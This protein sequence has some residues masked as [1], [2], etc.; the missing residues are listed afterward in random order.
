M[1]SSVIGA[2]RVML[3]M[4]SA[5]FEAGAT[6]AIRHAERLERRIGQMGDRLTGIGQALTIGLTAP[7]TAFGVSA[8]D[9]ASDA[10]ELESAFTQTF[11][12]LSGEMSRWAEETGDAMGR[13]TQSMQ[14]M[15]NTFGIF[16]NQAAP[17]REAAA[18]MSRTFSVLAQDLSSFYNVAESDA[19]A[20]LRSGLAGEAEPLRDFGVFLT[21]ASVKA[22]ALEMGLA[23]ASGEISEQA[24]IMARYQLIMEGTTNAQGDVARTSD[25]TANRIRAARAAF[26]ELQVTVG[27]K[28][29]PVITP[30]VEKLADVLNAFSRLPPGVQT[31]AVGVG[32][33]AAALGPLLMGIGGIMSS[34]APLIAKLGML[35]GSGGV[36]AGVGTGFTGLLATL[37]PI[38]VP[39]AAVAAAGALIYA[40]W[41]KIAPV[42]EQLW[43]T[44]QETLGPP[45]EQLV[46]TITATF[47]QF[48]EGPL[49]EGVR[50]AAGKL[51]EFYTA[52]NRV[53]GSVLI[54]IL[55]TVVE[56]V[57]WAFDLV[58]R[59]IRLVNQLLT[60]DW[61]AAWNSVKG[62]VDAVAPG[63]TGLVGRMVDGVISAFNRL[64]APF[65]WVVEQAQRVERAFFDMADK[66]TFRSWVPDM[67]DLIG[68]NFARLQGNMVDPALDATAT[69]ENAFATMA[70][71]VLGELQ[72]MANAIK[73][74]GFF[75]ILN[76]GIGLATKYLPGLLGGGGTFTGG[77]AAWARASAIPGFAS[78]GAMRLGGMAGIDRN[79]L[80][81]NGSPLA[82]VSAGEVLNVSPANANGGGAMHVTVTMDP[83]TG[84]LGAFVAD[85]AGRVLARATPSLVQAGAD[86]GVAKM[87][88]LRDRA[89][90]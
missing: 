1:A 59:S 30:L 65:D 9:A 6:S 88:R 81:L 54:N 77:D 35:G 52:Y 36:L 79:L 32:A 89:F 64:R 87:N 38:A 40:N 31:F 78:G 47:T 39:L 68:Q 21:E 48:W 25:G 15:A 28:L 62:I 76:A 86:A 24:K 8:F 11:G 90:S 61:G 26:E 17:T 45:L 10:A 29:I 51:G 70:Q 69:T 5:E 80:S 19:L 73:S 13:S 83:S 16:F 37:A 58:G 75:D 4:D 41:D 56:K 63:V 14:Q 53:L 85:Q 12:S 23:D 34:T 55:R 66:V 57:T 67:V 42:L 50:M 74:G 18:E 20:K 3:G 33:A 7:L 72:G 43:Q 60:G 84:A 44:A 22:K 49:G 27:E 82:R 46:A 71:N 2:L